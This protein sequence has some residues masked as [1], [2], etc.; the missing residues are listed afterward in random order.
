MSVTTT[1]GPTHLLTDQSG[2]QIIQSAAYNAAG[3]LQ[4]MQGGSAGGAYGGQSFSYNATLQLTGVSGGGMN[5]QYNYSSTT[6][7]RSFPRWTWSAASRSTS[8]TTH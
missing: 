5:I 7:A 2:T 8:R 3:Q 1:N 6:T 4:Q